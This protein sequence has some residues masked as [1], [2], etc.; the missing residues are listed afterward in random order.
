MPRLFVG[1]ML[2]FSLVWFPLDKE[3]SACAPVGLPVPLFVDA[4]VTVT[5]LVCT[6]ALWDVFMRN[7]SEP[8]DAEHVCDFYSPLGFSLSVHVEIQ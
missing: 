6:C 2:L 1:L 4:C 3:E 5:Q 7:R 8:S